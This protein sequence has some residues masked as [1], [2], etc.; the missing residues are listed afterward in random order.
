MVGQQG[1]WQ[2]VCVRCF[3]PCVVMC[4]VDGVSDTC[5]PALLVM[6]V[7]VGLCNRALLKR[8]FQQLWHIPGQTSVCS[9]CRLWLGHISF[10][11]AGQEAFQTLSVVTLVV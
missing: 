10:V 9:L 4:G 8:Q 3:W 7:H 2:L 5:Q 11:K 6:L 1:H